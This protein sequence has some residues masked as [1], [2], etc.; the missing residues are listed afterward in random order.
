MTM[1]A[2]ELV[3]SSG[4]TFGV[5]G[6]NLAEMFVQML[7]AYDFHQYVR[8]GHNFLFRHPFCIIIYQSYNSVLH[9]H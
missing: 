9:I 1:G 7:V 4:N 2:T 8:L 5:F 6:S 3:G